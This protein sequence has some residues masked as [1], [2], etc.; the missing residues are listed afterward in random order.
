MRHAADVVDMDHVGYRVTLW[1]TDSGG[2]RYRQMESGATLF[3]PAEAAV[4][5]LPYRLQWGATA[6]TL[7]LEFLGRTADRLVVDNHDWRTYRLVVPEAHGTR[8]FLPLTL[9]V[10]QGDDAAVLL[11][12]MT[13]R[14]RQG[15]R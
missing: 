1:N 7:Q 3:V 5:E 13:V 10:L 14:N 6:V 8:R 11:G 12:K 15:V 2:V 4:V 9:T